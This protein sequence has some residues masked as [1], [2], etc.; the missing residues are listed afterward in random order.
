MTRSGARAARPTLPLRRAWERASLYLPVLLLGLLA[1]AT[2]WLVRNAPHPEQPQ[3]PQA[4][5]HEPD[6]YMRDFSVKSFEAEGRLGSELRG[7]RLL[8]FPDTD[9]LE[10]EQ[11][12]M[13][14][15]TEDGRVVTARAQRALSNADGSEVQ[16]FGQASVVREPLAQPGGVPTPRLEFAGEFLHAWTREERVRSDQPVTLRRGGDTFTADRLEYDH[17]AQVLELHGHV[18]GSLAAPPPR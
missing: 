10:I 18:R 5:R 11:P 12:R 16:L 8:H 13:R 1:L 4:P 7:T 3:G 2:W 6:Y 14:S 17:A 9:T 15:V